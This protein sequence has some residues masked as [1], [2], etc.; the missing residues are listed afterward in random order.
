MTTEI[1]LKDQLQRLLRH[2]KFHTGQREKS[3]WRRDNFRFLWHVP[4]QVELLD[5][6]EITEPMDVWTG[7]ISASGIDF[8]SPRSLKRGQKVLITIETDDGRVQIHGIVVHSADLFSRHK[9]GV[10]LDLEDD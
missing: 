1:H 2:I 4:A 10:K 3:E 7:T 6:D 9:I 5:S 8:R